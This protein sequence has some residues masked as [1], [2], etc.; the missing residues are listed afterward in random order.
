MTRYFLSFAILFSLL[1]NAS[2]AEEPASLKP[3]MA[4]PNKVVFQSDFSKAKKLDKDELMIRQGTRWEIADGVLKGQESSKE[5]QAAREHHYGYEPRLSVPVTPKESITSFSFRFIGGEEG[6]VV[7]FIEFGHHHA[8]IKFTSDQGSWLLSDGEVFKV[9]EAKDFN[10]EAGKWYHALAECKGKEF[11]FQIKDGPTFYAKRDN[12]A[13]A[14]NHYL[15]ICGT[16]HGKVELDNLTI[17]S[18]KEET[19]SDWDKKAASFPAFEPVQVKQPK[20]K[21]KKK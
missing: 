19:Q 9:A 5:Y 3:F 20:A 21:K 10:F 15:G 16:K 1:S 11:V 12:Y 18:I 2:F 14:I 6:S 17:W 4:V 8:R 13:E 7:P